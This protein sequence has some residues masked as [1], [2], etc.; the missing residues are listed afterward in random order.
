MTTKYSTLL[1]YTILLGAPLARAPICNA[2]QF[3]SDSHGYRIELPHD[4]VEIP[5]DVLQ[6]TIAAL[7]KQNSTGNIIYDAGFQLASARQWFEYPHVIVMPLPYAKLGLH[8]QLNE[9]E[10]PKYVRMLTG[11]DVDKSVDEYLSSDVRQRLTNIDAGQPQLDVANRRF[12][13][14]MNSDVEGDGPIRGLIVGYFGR[15]AI[16]QVMF[17]SRRADWDR[18]ADVRATIVDSF[19]FDPNK[20][21]SVQV[22]ASNPTPPSIWSRVLANGIAFGIVAGLLALISVVVAVATRKKTGVTQDAVD[23]EEKVSGWNAM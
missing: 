4:W 9:D 23:G 17:Y 14:T 16:V 5:Q 13:W 22:A 6:E 3:H 8:R 20:A 12:V 19:R 1:L 7:R 11:I 15:D 18:Y 21:Y 2:D 10:F